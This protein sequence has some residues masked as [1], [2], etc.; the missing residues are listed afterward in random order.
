MSKPTRLLGRLAA[1]ALIAAIVGLAGCG[2]DRSGGPTGRPEDVVGAAPDLTLAAGTA[3]VR[4]NAP[5]AAAQ[6]VVDL[7]AHSGRLSVSDVSFGKPADLLITGGTG[8]IK[9]ASD[10]VWTVVDGSLPETLRGGNPFANLDLI[11]GTVHI[12]SDGGGE[13]DGFS[14]IRYT[15]TID[16][17]QAITVTPPARQTALR[18][19][20]QGRTKL[21]TMDVW[22]DSKRLVRRVE[23]STDLRPTTPSTRSD[24]LP[25]ATDVDYLAFGVAVPPVQAPPTA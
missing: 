1:A 10:R 11:R 12:L 23:L 25:I 18:S 20:L 9:Q 5:V 16:P 17:G 3:R 24:R 15:L 13:V 22:I 14:T 6:G 8:Y 2:G 7:R 4:I 21:F 19:V